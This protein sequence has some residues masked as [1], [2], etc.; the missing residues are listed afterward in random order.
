[1]DREPEAGFGSHPWGGGEGG[2]LHG[3]GVEERRQRWGLGYAECE[4]KCGVD[5]SEGA[6]RRAFFSSREYYVLVG[7]GGFVVVV[8]AVGETN[9]GLV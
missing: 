8:V 3:G 2:G 7:A 9:K 6:V 4:G 1:M 5:G